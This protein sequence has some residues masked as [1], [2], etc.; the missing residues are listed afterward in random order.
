MSFEIEFGCTD[1]TFRGS[2]ILSSNSEKFSILANDIEV[3][4]NVKM[5]NVLS[6]VTCTAAINDLGL[7]S[8]DMIWFT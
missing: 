5:S 4:V 3:E 6:P 8:G 7:V 2:P 1:A